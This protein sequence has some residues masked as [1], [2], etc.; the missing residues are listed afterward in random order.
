MLWL[1][2]FSRGGNSVE[3]EPQYPFQKML[4]LSISH[5]IHNILLL[6]FFLENGAKKR[7]SSEKRKHHTHAGYLLELHQL[8][9]S[10]K[11]PKYMFPEVLNT[12]FLHNFWLVATSSA[13]IWC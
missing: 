13:K 7:N 4:F 5:Q 8:G 10:N 3:E 6:F 2:H 1:V 9:D 12:M 11:H